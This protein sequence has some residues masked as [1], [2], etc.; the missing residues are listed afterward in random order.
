MSAPF[1]FVFF[2]KIKEE[3][4]RDLRD[5]Y[6]IGKKEERKKERKKERNAIKNCRQ[7]ISD[8]R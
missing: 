6:F 1:F 5:H 8:E 2:S 3:E 4:E 7:R